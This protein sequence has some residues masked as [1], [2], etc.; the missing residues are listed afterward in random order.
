MEVEMLDKRWVILGSTRCPW[1]E[2]VKALL[3]TRGIPF[4]YFNIN[5]HPELA[6]FAKASGLSTV[7]QVYVD[8]TNVGGFEAT[9]AML[10]INEA[11]P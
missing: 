5:V 9:K 10:D 3:S 11:F 2:R 1:C 7:P 4:T 8:G 6:E